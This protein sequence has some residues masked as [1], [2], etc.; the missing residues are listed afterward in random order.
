M[1]T[2]KSPARSFRTEAFALSEKIAAAWVGFA[3]RG[4]PNVPVLLR[5]PAYSPE[6]RDSLMFKNQGRVEE[7]PDRGS[8]P[9]DGE[10]AQ[11]VLIPVP[12]S[13]PVLGSC[14][15]I[16]TFSLAQKSNVSVGPGTIKD[17][18]E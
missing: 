3:H 12:L 7:D 8:T 6:T 10:S 13:D 17:D 1:K 2:L 11:I 14:G 18:K 5:W 4:N 9:R 15:K 16:L